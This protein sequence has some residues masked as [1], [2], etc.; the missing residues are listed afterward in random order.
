MVLLVLFVSLSQWQLNRARYKQGLLDQ[1]QIRTQQPPVLLTEDMGQPH[2][3]RYKPVRIK[4]VAET[5]H[6]FLLDNQIVHGRAGYFVLLP[7]KLSSGDGILVNRGWIPSDGQRDQKP[8]VGLDLTAFDGEGYLDAFP[9]V[10]MKLEGAEIPGPGWPSLLQVVDTESV[11]ARLGFALLPFQA[12][13]E[14]GHPAS[15]SPIPRSLPMGP[16]KHYGYAVQWAA[17]AF[18]LV[19]IYGW[20]SWRGSTDE[21]EMS[22]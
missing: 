16:E 22:K 11:S 3:W 1:Q 18:T 2:D 5:E 20:L 7:V 10:G 17:L 21:E 19:V 14:K 13:L 9:V 12:V 6:Q 4:G 15:L 8:D